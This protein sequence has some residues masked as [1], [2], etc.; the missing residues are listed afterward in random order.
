MAQVEENNFVSFTTQQGLT[1]NDVNCIH[2]DNLGFLW[3]GTKFGLNRFDGL[4]F[5]H[6][7][8]DSKGEPLPSDEILD[9]LQLDEDRIL[10]ATRNGLQQINTQSLDQHNL[11]IPAGP[12]SS[13]LKV[14]TIRSVL[15]DT[16]ENIYIAT[17]SG[18]YHLH[19][20]GNLLFRYDDYL[21]ENESHSFGFGTHMGWL[22]R[23][24]IIVTGQHGEYIYNTEFRQFTKIENQHPDFN[25][26]GQ[27]HQ[28]GKRN[29]IIR[30]PWPGMFF[31]FYASS[32][33]ISIVDENRDRVFFSS[34]TPDIAKDEF[35]WRSNMSFVQADSGFWMTGKFAG[36]FKIL[37]N[38]KY[39]TVQVVNEKY[40]PSVKCNTVFKDKDGNLWLGSTMGLWKLRTSTANRL[41]GRIPEDKIDKIPTGYITQIAIVGQSLYAAASHTGGLYRFDPHT[42][43]YNTFYPFAWSD[44]GNKSLITML[45]WS[46]D[47]ILCGTDSGLYWFHA[48]TKQNEFVPFPDI[49]GYKTTI[50]DLVRD[51]ENGIWVITNATDKCY[52]YDLS[53]NPGY[54]QVIQFPKKNKLAKINHVTTDY[55]GNVWLGGSGLARYN[56]I[57]REF[58]FYTDQFLNTINDSK[59]VHALAADPYGHLWFSIAINGLTQYHIGS[60]TQRRF[61]IE[62]G[63]PDNHVRSIFCDSQYV[64]IACRTGIARLDLIS[65]EIKTVW[66]DVDMDQLHVTGRG[67]LVDPTSSMFYVASGFDILSF[68]PDQYEIEKSH[69]ILLLEH[70]GLGSDSVVW[71]P[72]NDI[73]TTWKYRNIALTFS[74]INFQ[75]GEDQEYFY[76][77]EDIG[78]TSWVKLGKQRRIYLN[79][80]SPG[81]YAI[82]VKVASRNH[83][84]PSQEL[85]VS[86]FV[87]APF[88]MTWWFFVLLA[89]GLLSLLYAL[90]RYRIRQLRK[91]Y[92]VREGI[93][94]DLHD[95][96]GST[97]SG[98]AM[99]SHVAQSQL[100][101][102]HPM[103]ARESIHIIQ[104][105][106]TDMV[107]RLNDI[108]WTIQPKHDSLQKLT[109]RLQ[110]FGSEASVASGIR[111]NTHISAKLN[112]VKLPMKSRHSI[113]LVCKE[114]MH[115]A[116]KYSHAETLDLYV[117]DTGQGLLFEVVDNGCG[118]D[119]GQ[120]KRGNGLDNMQAR[121]EEIKAH[122]AIHSHPNQGTS[123][124][125]T[126]KFK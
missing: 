93:S 87:K 101:S 95:E 120:I 32:D 44:Y 57:T 37:F 69:P 50:K 29:Y 33:T 98:I 2:Q 47:S 79:N 24:N 110:E 45:P 7:Y 66:R 42:L 70:I 78:D 81:R 86:L 92:Q 82:T 65:F 113:Y 76:R 4:N 116:I 10:I 15:L 6:F 18:F 63:L 85:P 112:D 100:H 23:R 64:W 3:I 43:E 119:A 88:W 126:Y 49:N 28:L 19:E 14:N 80:L 73:R 90:Y 40:L 102:E 107:T 72:G 68:S 71:N 13:A 108:V 67:M 56:M 122:F 1:H 62:D 94:R 60:G 74:S 31:I 16:T 5:L 48:T 26:F 39:S 22:D 59:T 109:E 53:M 35:T 8:N 97:L 124:R 106:A 12:Y 105:S 84:W 125:L 96:V 21:P 17:R 111:V 54:M 91:I 75:D 34:G 83:W 46:K 103:S 99:Y 89:L 123:V 58:D 30:Q 118:F 38:A 77:F 36:L 27:L 61:N 11:L 41:Q 52:R 55:T 20:D 117:R 114:A 51:R 121:A 25:I 9:I 115:N 104:K